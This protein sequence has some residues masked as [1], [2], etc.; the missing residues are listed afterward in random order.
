MALDTALPTGDTGIYL[1]TADGHWYYWN[2]SAWTTDCSYSI[3]DNVHG[4][5]IYNDLTQN[6]FTITC[7]ERIVVVFNA[8]NF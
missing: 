6:M 7:D 4:S 8:A 1:V 5:L 3:Y 2:G